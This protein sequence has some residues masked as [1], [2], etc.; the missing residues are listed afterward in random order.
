MD[1][2]R[3]HIPTVDDVFLKVTDMMKTPASETNPGQVGE[4]IDEQKAVLKN[5]D[6]DVKDAKR[7]IN[8]AKGPRPKAVVNADAQSGSESD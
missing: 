2:L 7:R 1:C 4:F 6:A 3:N 5:V 8:A